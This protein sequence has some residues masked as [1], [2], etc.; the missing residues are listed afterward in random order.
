MI[1]GNKM[2]SQ[3]I[4]VIVRGAVDVGLIAD[5]FFGSHELRVITALYG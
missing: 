5:K 2:H 4:L 3:L 1:H